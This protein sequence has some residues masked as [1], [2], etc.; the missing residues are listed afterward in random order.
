MK[1]IPIFFDKP[2]VRKTLKIEDICIKEQ[3]LFTQKELKFH[4]IRQF[5]FTL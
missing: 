1:F 2:N 3:L 5:F 4:M